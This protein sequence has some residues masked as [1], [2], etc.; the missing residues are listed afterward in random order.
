MRTRALRAGRPTWLSIS[1][2]KPWT[3]G[4]ECAMASGTSCT[5]VRPW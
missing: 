2:T 5:P 1:F 4:S 3:A